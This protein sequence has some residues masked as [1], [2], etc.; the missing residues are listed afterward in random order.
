[1]AA[2][3]P[4]ALV[5]GPFH[6]AERP[7]GISLPGGVSQTKAPTISARR[8]FPRCRPPPWRS[9]C[10]RI[11]RGRSMPHAC[12]PW[13]HEGA[14]A[15]ALRIRMP[16]ALAYASRSPSNPATSIVRKARTAPVG[17]HP[18]SRQFQSRGWRKADPYKDA[19]RGSIAGFAS[20]IT[21]TT[22]SGD[23]REAIKKIFFFFFFFFFFF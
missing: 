5:S 6:Y 3:S 10:R 11:A 16:R 17:A 8:A 4:R 20:T 13:A 9:S 15:T 19:A 21:P 23:A 14:G 1:V 2:R 22:P 18:E 12:S 7:L